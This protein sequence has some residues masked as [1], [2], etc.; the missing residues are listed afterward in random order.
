ME[1]MNLLPNSYLRAEMGCTPANAHADSYAPI[2]RDDKSRLYNATSCHLL[3]ASYASVLATSSLCEAWQ[4]LLT[5]VALCY[6]C[7]TFIFCRPTVFGFV[8]APANIFS[9]F[10]KGTYTHVGYLPTYTPGT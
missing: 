2:D 6:I 3:N 10:I 7:L 1:R 5:T 9:H 8:T 4:G